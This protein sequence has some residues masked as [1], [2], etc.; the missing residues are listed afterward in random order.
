MNDF[1]TI[2][3]LKNLFNDQDYG[4]I[5]RNGFFIN[6]LA[7]PNAKEFEITKVCEHCGSKYKDLD[8]KKRLR[9]ATDSYRKEDGRLYHLF[10]QG[11]F[12]LHNLEQNDKAERAFSIAWEKGHS[13]GYLEVYQEFEDLVD[14][15]K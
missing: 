14:L 4:T 12:L 15:I 2:E 3:N 11:L 5:I 6:T 9:E 8:A 1:Q 13:S 7:Y 10:K